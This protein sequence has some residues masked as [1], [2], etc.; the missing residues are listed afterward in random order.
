[1]IRDSF[2]VIVIV[3]MFPFDKCEAV[4]GQKVTIY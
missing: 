3:K 4:K 1:M 2:F